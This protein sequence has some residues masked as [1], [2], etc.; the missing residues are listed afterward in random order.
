M[1]IKN[2]SLKLRRTSHC[3]LQTV[4]DYFTRMT[5]DISKTSGK[6]KKLKKYQNKFFKFKTLTTN[7][8]ISLVD[9]NNHTQQISYLKPWKY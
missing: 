2:S 4:E 7:V 6:S 1:K 8:H 9:S 3:R 5:I